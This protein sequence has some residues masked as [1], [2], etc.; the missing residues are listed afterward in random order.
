MAK[1][2]LSTTKGDITLELDE[3]EA[4]ISTENFLGYV[5][6]GFYDGLIFHRV[7]DGFMIQGGGFTPD[8]QQ[9]KAGNTIKNEWQNNLSNKRGAIAMARI[10][11]DPDSASSQFFIN[12]KD[13]AFLDQEQPDGAAYAVFGEVV[14]GLD[15]VDEI[16]N[17]DTTNKA[18]HGDVPVEPVVINSA[19]RI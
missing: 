2:K 1:V 17:V 14:D 5:D 4:P 18:G 8:M 6:E 12:V 16:K 7:I 13:N 15:V 9:K 19:T 3:N 10:G 11:G